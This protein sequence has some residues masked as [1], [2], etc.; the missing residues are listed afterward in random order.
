M[1]GADRLVLRTGNGFSDLL[2]LV[3]VP[4]R[5][6]VIGAEGPFYSSGDWWT[7]EGW[8]RSEWDVQLAEGA[9]C[10]IY[11][12]TEAWFLEGIYD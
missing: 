3:S 9:L 8:D 4:L 5:G 10:R 1:A 7:G 2:M 6:A 11:Q 12:E